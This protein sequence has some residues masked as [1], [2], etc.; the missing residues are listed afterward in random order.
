MFYQKSLISIFLIFFISCNNLQKNPIDTEVLS[1]EFETQ[2]GDILKI[3]NQLSKV[4]VILFFFTRC[5]TVCIETNLKMKEI[6]EHFSDFDNLNLI[7]I[8]IDPDFDNTEVLKEYSSRYL[9]DKDRW[10]FVRAQNKYDI[11][12]ILKRGFDEQVF[13]EFYHPDYIY[14]LDK[15]G[16]LYSKH[17]PLDEKEFNDLNKNLLKLLQEQ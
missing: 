13:D 5:K 16:Y 6:S 4:Q 7:S 3:E 17:N 12:M 11:N 9:N 10:A 2:N 8:S 14:L 15:G 1:Y